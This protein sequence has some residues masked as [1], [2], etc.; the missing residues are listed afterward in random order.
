MPVEYTDL[1]QLEKG[2][3]FLWINFVFLCLPK[4][5]MSWTNQRPT[6]LLLWLLSLLPSQG[7]HSS[8]MSAQPLSYPSAQQ[9]LIV[10]IWGALAL[11]FFIPNLKFIFDSVLFPVRAPLHCS[12]IQKNVSE[13]LSSLPA[14]T[15]SSLPFSMF[16]F[17]LT[18]ILGRRRIGWALSSGSSFVFPHITGP[19]NT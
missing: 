16:H 15:F 1:D 18:S 7:F 19:L 4:E 12:L 10:S 5:V 13:M 2:E 3:W 6:W 14:S 11:I 9:V 17:N 8:A